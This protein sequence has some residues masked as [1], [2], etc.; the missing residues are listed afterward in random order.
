MKVQLLND[1]A[2]VPTRGTEHAAGYDLFCVGDYTIEPS[3]SAMIATGVAMAIDHG[4]AGLIWPRSGLAVKHSLDTLA[5]L[6]DSDYRGEIKVVMINLGNK[7]V[8]FK[9]GD[10]IAQI[11]FQQVYQNDLLVVASV[12]DTDRGDGGF[13][14]TGVR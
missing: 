8:T 2:K 3:A 10:R 9:T 5:G 14:S 4:W 7:A 12:D 11:V 1:Q 6:I 13:G